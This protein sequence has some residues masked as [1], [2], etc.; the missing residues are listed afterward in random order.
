[1]EDPITSLSANLIACSDPTEARAIAL[2][3][4]EAINERIDYLRD[5]AQEIKRAS[6]KSPHKK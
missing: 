6:N 4:R 2:E 5:K 1:M 3:L